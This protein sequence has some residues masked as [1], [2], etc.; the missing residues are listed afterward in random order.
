MADSP[1][2]FRL[3]ADS[4]AQSS[5]G[6]KQRE[7]KMGNGG[8]GNTGRGGERHP[9]FPRIASGGPISFCPTKRNRRKK[10]R[11]GNLPKGSPGPLLPAKGGRLP[12]IG[13][14]RICHLVPLFRAEL[15][16]FVSRPYS[17]RSV[18]FSRK[19]RSNRELASFPVS[20]ANREN[21][22]CEICDDDCRAAKRS[23][24]RHDAV[25]R[26]RA[27]FYSPKN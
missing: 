5:S 26:T 12:P 16:S 21:D 9:A 2:L 20:F 1:S 6:A 27:L 25:P 23:G 10:N 11:P 13:S 17:W 24:G 4:I 3:A 8:T 19:R 18:R 15:P 14:P 22:A 7:E